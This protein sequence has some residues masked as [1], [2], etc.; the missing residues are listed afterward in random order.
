MNAFATGRL[1]LTGP[2]VAVTFAALTMGCTHEYQITPA[3]ERSLAELPGRAVCAHDESLAV[4]VVNESARPLDAGEV[5]A[6][7]H[8]FNHHFAEDPVRALQAGLTAALRDGH[9]ATSSPATAALQ[10]VLVRME[11]HGQSCGFVTCDGTAEAKVSVTLR[12]ASGR[13]LSEHTISTSAQQ[14]CGLTFCNEEES[15]HLATQAISKAVGKTVLAI[16]QALAK[17]PSQQTAAA[18]PPGS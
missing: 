5:T 9:C 7:I 18:A 13:T 17:M 2:I 4:S 3:Y 11:A 14:S 1:F 8:T 12:D 15:S 16:S 6:G 10:V